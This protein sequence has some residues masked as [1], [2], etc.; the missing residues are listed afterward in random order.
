MKSALLL[1]LNSSD[2]VESCI[3]AMTVVVQMLTWELL[4]RLLIRDLVRVI[5]ERNKRSAETLER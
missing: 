3:Y 2:Q 1:L 4:D 5:D